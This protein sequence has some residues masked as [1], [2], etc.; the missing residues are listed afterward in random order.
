[1]YTRALSWLLVP[2]MLFCRWLSDLVSAGTEYIL[3]CMEQCRASV[4]QMVHRISVFY[5]RHVSDLHTSPMSFCCTN[6][7]AHF[8]EKN[9]AAPS[10]PMKNPTPDARLGRRSLGSWVRIWDSARKSPSPGSNTSQGYETTPQSIRQHKPTTTSNTSP[11][12]SQ[13]PSPL[14][15][16]P[17]PLQVQVYLHHRLPIHKL[18]TPEAVRLHFAHLPFIYQD[19]ADGCLAQAAAMAPGPAREQ[20]Q[21]MWI[22]SMR[23]AKRYRGL[24]IVLSDRFL[25]SVLARHAS[26]KRPSRFW[27]KVLDEIERANSSWSLTRIWIMLSVAQSALAVLIAKLLPPSAQAGVMLANAAAYVWSA[28]MQWH[29]VHSRYAAVKADEQLLHDT[30][31]R[32]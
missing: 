7:S 25:R 4:Q 13:S 18:P 24:S 10:S 6:N 12:C 27:E 16:S 19:L 3:W 8:T 9:D 21:R 1:M 23:L 20:R 29:M 17:F 32:L 30:M 15:P 28:T 2:P 5:S 26:I 11:P 14:G 22:L 31:G